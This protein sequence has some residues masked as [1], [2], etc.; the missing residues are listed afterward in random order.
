MRNDDAFVQLGSDMIHGKVAAEELNVS[1]SVVA[2]LQ[3]RRDKAKER[4]AGSYAFFG[5]CSGDFF[6][7]ISPRQALFTA[8][9]MTFIAGSLFLIRGILE[10]LTEVSYNNLKHF[11]VEPILTAVIPDVVPIIC[12]VEV[13][14]PFGLVSYA[15]A[16]VRPVEVMFGSPGSPPPRHASSPSPDRTLSSTARVLPNG[17]SEPAMY[18]STGVNNAIATV[19]KVGVVEPP[20]TPSR[21]PVVTR[22]VTRAQ[23]VVPPGVGGG[24]VALY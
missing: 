2:L 5:K 13:L 23:P 19:P 21:M 14:L 22:A 18:G 24:V 6:F 15:R 20:S 17:I 1:A 3:Y 8:G 4:V 7:L 12:I 9:F 10:G 16:C 11:L